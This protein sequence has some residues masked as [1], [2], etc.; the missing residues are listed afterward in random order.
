[1]PTY[2]YR[3]KDCEKTFERMERMSEHEDAHPKCPECG[4]KKVEQIFASFFAK[5][6]RKS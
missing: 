5:T 4:S 1:M 3:C 6:S 2:T